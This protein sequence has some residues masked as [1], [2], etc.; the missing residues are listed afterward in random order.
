MAPFHQVHSF[1]VRVAVVVAEEY[2]RQAAEACIHS[3]DIHYIHALSLVPVRPS[4]Y[5]AD[6]GSKSSCTAGLDLVV[7]IAEIAVGQTC[8]DRHMV[9]CCMAQVGAGG[10]ACDYVPNRWV[11]VGID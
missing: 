11:Q 7:G 10:E 9:H 3:E 8:L 1:E 4:D 2:A 5:A 6:W